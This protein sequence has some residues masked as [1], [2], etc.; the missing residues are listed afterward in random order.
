MNG[1]CSF[2][3]TKRTFFAVPKSSKV[4]Q[5]T[6]SRPPVNRQFFRKPGQVPPG[7]AFRAKA[8]RGRNMTLNNTKRPYQC[9]IV[10]EVYGSLMVF[11]FLLLRSRK[12]SKKKYIDK[13]CPRFTTTGMYTITSFLSRSR[14]PRLIFEKSDFFFLLPDTCLPSAFS[15]FVCSD[16]LRT[17]FL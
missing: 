13:P 7:R 11:F 17:N 4:A 3:F 10:L 16:P 12:A 15:P 6:S 14:V 1:T 8:R 5:V 9:V 2:C